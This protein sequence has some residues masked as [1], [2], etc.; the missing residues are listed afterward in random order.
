MTSQVL[1]A[2]GMEYRHA[3]VPGFA[4]RFGRSVFHCPFCHGWEVRDQPLGVYDPTVTGTLRALLLRNWSDDVVLFTDGRALEEKEQAVLEAEGVRVESRPVASLDGAAPM[5][6]SV[7]LADGDSVARTGLLVPVTLHQRSD[8]ASRLGAVA[9]APGPLS[10]D[11]IE[12]NWM[13]Q[14]SVPGLSAAGDTCTQMPSVAAAVAAGSLAAAMLVHGA[15]A[16]R[17]DAPTA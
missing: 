1:L 12:V 17:L 14:T 7:V 4:E 15:V 5:L 6:E 8:L 9:A 3:D 10:A 11:A 16:A 13:F 2:T